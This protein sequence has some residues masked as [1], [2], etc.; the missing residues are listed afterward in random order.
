MKKTNTKHKVIL[1]VVGLSLLVLVAVSFWYLSRQNIA[2]LNPKGPIALKEYHLIVFSL[3]LS[4]LVVVPVFTLLFV[5]SIR[6][7]EK[8]TKSKYS[9]NLDHSK[10]FETIWWLIPSALITV[11]AVVAWNSSH[12][13]DP[14]KRIS[15]TNKTLNIQVV[16]L[17]WKWLFIYPQ[18]NIAT[19]NYFQIP[20]QTPVNFEITSDAPMNSFWIPNLGGQIYA[21]P[22]MSTQLNLLASNN[23][24]YPGSS[25]NISGQGFSGMTFNVKSSSMNNFNDWV[26][27]VKQSQ[28]R[29]TLARYNNLSQPSL[30][31]GISYYS[32]A[33]PNLYNNIVYK[34]LTPT[35]AEANPD[36]TSKTQNIPNVQQLVQQG[37]QGMSM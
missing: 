26:A 13:L 4:L 28:A 11:L 19:V 10:I 27:Q 33:E 34:Y 17:N 14:Y 35:S 37:M 25:A 29:L 36:N 8:N 21:M 9:P 32:Y 15:S 24:T 31:N 30:N 20:N 2:V 22:G 23:G 5:F 1:L 6:Y 18:Q 12:D 16:A 3:L 7:S